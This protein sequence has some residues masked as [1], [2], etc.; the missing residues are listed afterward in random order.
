MRLVQTPPGCSIPLAANDFT[1]TETGCGLRREVLLRAPGCNSGIVGDL[2]MRQMPCDGLRCPVFG[3]SALVRC[4]D[5]TSE[6]EDFL[7]DEDHVIP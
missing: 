1:G 2:S 6:S 3:I 7:K 5:R 4:Q